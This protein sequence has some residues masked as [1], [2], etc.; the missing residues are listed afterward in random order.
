MSSATFSPTSEQLALRDA[1]AS[2]APPLPLVNLEKGQIVPRSWLTVQDGHQT[3]SWSVRIMT[4]NVLIPRKYQGRELFPHSDCLKSAQREHMLFN[5]ILSSDGDILCLQEVDRLE[6]LIPVLEEAK[7]GHVYAAGPRKKH[8]SLIAFRKD[9]YKIHGNIVV[10]YD[11]IDIRPD[12]SESSRKGLSFRTKNVGN[13]VALEK[14]GDP[15]EGYIVATTHLFWHPSQAGI[16]L[17]EVVKYR[18]GL[19]LS[20]WPCILAGDFNFHPGEPGYALLAGDALTLAQEQLLAKSRVVHVSVD[21]SVPLTASSNEDDE[22]DPDRVI[23][24]AREALPA[25]GL[26]SSPELVELFA[27]PTRPRSLYDEG[28]RLLEMTSGPILRCGERLGLPA[29]RRGAYEPEWTSYTHYWKSVL[30][31]IWVID[32]SDQRAVVTRLLQPHITDNLEP[33]LPR[34]GVCGSDHVSLATEVRWEGGD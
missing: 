12:G 11:D 23:T 27:V 6:K 15:S 25:D 32:P 5:E 9:S 31:Y 3:T 2:A 17:R 13:I 28:Q 1:P 29:H 14:V 20:S 18:E 24:N 19:G 21:P 8:G 10:C 30:D 4:W 7:Y 22:S 33:G 16:L 26:L 34:K